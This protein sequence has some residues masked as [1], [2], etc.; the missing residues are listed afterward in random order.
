MSGIMGFINL[1]GRPAASEHFGAMA[2]AM[3]GWGPD[4][5]GS[6]LSRNAALG[7][8][9]LMITPESRFEKMPCYDEQTNIFFTAAA[10]LDNR[11]ELLD[12]LNLPPDENRTTP[13]GMIVFRA[14]KKWG[15]EA[16]RH[17]FGDWSFAAWHS[18][19]QRLFLARDHLGNTGLYYYFKPPLLVFA[20]NTE[21]ILAHPEVSREP[22]EIQLAK[23]LGV[24]IADRDY[25]GTF[26]KDV[27]YLPSAHTLTV[28]GTGKAL[29][30]YWRL[31]D[32]APVKLSSDEDYLEG[33][34]DHFRRAV[35]VRLNSIR[36][37]GSQLSAG[38]DSSAVT[39]LAAQ[40]LQ[41]KHQPLV[42]YTSVPL[43]PA[44]ELFPGRLTDEW[45][46]ARQV[47]ER[48]GNIE[49]IRIPADDFTPLD[50]I[51]RS[52]DIT[53]APQH[54]AGN[55][56]WIISLFEHAQ[57]RNLGVMLTGQLGNGSVSWSGGQDYIFYLLLRK[58]WRKV[59]RTLAARKKRGGYSWYRTLKSNILRPL[60]LPLWSQWR[61]F[62]NFRDSVRIQYSFPQPDF[63]RRLGLN[64]S[65][66]KRP[67][68]KRIDPLTERILTVV[69]N[70]T[71]VGPIWH[72]FGSFYNMD[73]RDPTADVRLMEFCMGVPDEQDTFE[74]G[75]RMLIRRAMAG[76]LPEAIRW[77]TARGKQA[78]DVVGRLM[79][80][81]SDVERQ[82]I[83]FRS[84]GDVTRYIDVDAMQKAWDAM[85]L[86]SSSEM[87]YGFL[88]ALNTAYFLFSI[89]GNKRRN[90]R[91]KKIKEGTTESC[92]TDAK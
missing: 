58:E 46:L 86:S 85:S 27:C 31:E 15:D 8:A 62:S 36:P 87:A 23:N 76:I 54:A 71:M 70:G 92:I 44:E 75:Q 61:N 30:Q 42:A 79:N 68:S 53:H 57:R 69:R 63:I 74:G 5:I 88:R 20:S 43:H 81:R 9:L 13:D 89:S 77:N 66:I 50:A 51:Q 82:I 25:S 17:I 60:L 39:A 65:A 33:F 47:A 78:A 80:Q 4:R 3:T 73:V 18:K 55:M 59:L 16:C 29:H 52:L 24:D 37:V 14:Y 40:E 35:R 1:D 38:L 67:V 12:R 56:T 26:W 32:A 10:R 49:H 83:L 7:H 84:A 34:V 19:K 6:V 48:Y 72:S 21:G 45:P 11:A 22:D 64:E 2:E 91:N 90:D 28:T 41:K